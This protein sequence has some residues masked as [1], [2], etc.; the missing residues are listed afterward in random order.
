MKAYGNGMKATEFSKKQISVI[1]SKAKT[2]ELKVEKWIMSDMYDMA[3]F[4]GYDF[5]GT[6]ANEEFRIKQILEAVFAGNL[7]E[8]QERIDAFTESLYSCLGIKAK[9][10]ADRNLI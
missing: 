3:D 1:Y 9:K 6:A 7:E 10:N 4:Y 8:A 2:G 5:N